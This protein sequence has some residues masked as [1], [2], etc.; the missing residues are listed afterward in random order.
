MTADVNH[1][2]DEGQMPAG[3]RLRTCIYGGSDKGGAPLKFVEE[4]AFEILEATRGVIVTGGFIHSTNHRDATSTDSAALKGARRF[5]Q[6]AEPRRPVAHWYEAVVPD[7]DVER[8][9]GRDVRMTKADKITLTVADGSTPLG[10]RLEM[11]ASVDA[12][13]TVAG[14]RNTEVIVEQALNLG[15]PVLPIPSTGGQSRRLMNAYPERIA[16]GFPPGS[17]DACLGTVAS[18]IRRH[19]QRAAEAVADLITQARIGRCLA[20]SPFDAAHR[21]LYDS[22]VE[23]AIGEQMLPVRLDET[24]NSDA[25]RK[26]F[27]TAIESSTAVVVDITKINDNVMFELG[28]AWGK[29]LRPLIYTRDKTR[30]S[31]LP[32]YLGDL[33]VHHAADHGQLRELIVDHLIDVKKARR[34]QRG[35]VDGGE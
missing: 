24:R 20:L 27:V 19:P 17:V 8:G 4:L 15:I 23:P 6:H 2:A 5:A 25:I 30:R 28:Y 12:V 18:T 7:P 9:T 13:V 16:A 10:R 34:G 35:S 32:L 3:R 21:E 22:V 29:G 33:N 31:N 26:N 11:V 14:S 1:L